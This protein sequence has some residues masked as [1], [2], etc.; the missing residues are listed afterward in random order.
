[1][2]PKGARDLSYIFWKNR[3]LRDSQS[4]AQKSG[5]EA[6]KGGKD[7]GNDGVRQVGRRYRYLIQ[8]SD[9]QRVSRGLKAQQFHGAGH[10]PDC[11]CDPAQVRGNALIHKKNA[12]SIT[13]GGRADSPRGGGWPA[14]RQVKNRALE[15]KTGWANLTV[16][17]SDSFSKRVLSHKTPS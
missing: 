3:V 13:A 9:L 17:S 14:G 16:D 10:E 5:Y 6:T 1:M 2:S 4:R 11:L 15:R 8:V 7:S 12:K